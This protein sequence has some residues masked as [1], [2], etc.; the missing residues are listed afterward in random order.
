MGATRCY[1]NVIR[2][3]SD[4]PAAATSTCPPNPYIVSRRICKCTFKPFV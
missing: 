4:A 2:R 1:N 3:K